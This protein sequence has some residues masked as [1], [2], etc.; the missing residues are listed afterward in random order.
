MRVKKILGPD[1]ALVEL[2]HCSF[3]MCVR[4]FLLFVRKQQLL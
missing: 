2:H 3:K 1:F 4:R